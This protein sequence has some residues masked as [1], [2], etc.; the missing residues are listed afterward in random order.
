MKYFIPNRKTWQTIMKAANYIWHLVHFNNIFIE[1][2]RNFI[3]FN[4]IDCHLQRML[5]WIVRSVRGATPIYIM[6]L[7]WRSWRHNVY[8]CE[9]KKKILLYSSEMLHKIGKTAMTTFTIT[10]K[11]IILFLLWNYAVHCE[12]WPSKA[13][14]FTNPCF[15]FKFSQNL[16]WQRILFW[17]NLHRCLYAG[18]SLNLVILIQVTFK[19]CVHFYHIRYCQ[20]MAKVLRLEIKHMNT[21]CSRFI[22]VPSIRDREL[23][24]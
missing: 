11:N 23:C 7:Y 4:T 5:Y 18:R 3:V 15:G 13:Q 20:G 6:L 19:F 17:K 21:R 24:M 12:N 10:Q 22:L 16:H 9:H 8:Y 2:D 14:L 1:I